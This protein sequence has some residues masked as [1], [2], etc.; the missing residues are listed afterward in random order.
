MCVSLHKRSYVGC[1]Q[2]GCFRDHS[3]TS[4][5]ELLGPIVE[6]N[7]LRINC[8]LPK[9]SAHSTRHARPVG[10]VLWIR[11]QPNL[12][13]IASSRRNVGRAYSPQATLGNALKHS[14]ATIHSSRTRHPVRLSIG[15]RF[16]NITARGAIQRY[17]PVL[18]SEQVRPMFGKSGPKEPLDVWMR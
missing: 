2:V 3:R 11:A 13:S 16:E 5:T 1:A 4:R 6:G 10:R 14:R 8:A 12:P 7:C 9:G 18:L 15:P 17:I